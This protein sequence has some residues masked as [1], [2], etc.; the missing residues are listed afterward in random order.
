M[1]SSSVNRID[2]ILT[3]IAIVPATQPHRNFI[4]SHTS[5]DFVPTK[6]NLTSSCISVVAG[7]FLTFRHY[8]AITNIS[9]QAKVV[10]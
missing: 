7:T 9:F 10:K 2:E 3:E 5:L 6:T 1:I 8:R 4:F